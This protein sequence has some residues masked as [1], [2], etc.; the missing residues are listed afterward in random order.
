MSLSKFG[1]GRSRSL[2]HSMEIYF[3]LIYN[4]Y[5]DLTF[6]RNIHKTRLQ[7]LLFTFSYL[8]YSLFHCSFFGHSFVSFDFVLCCAH[9]ACRRTHKQGDLYQITVTLSAG[10]GQMS[11]INIEY[12]LFRAVGKVAALH[13]THYVMPFKIFSTFF[14]RDSCFCGFSSAF[15]VI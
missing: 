10:G 5:K 12:K 1:A 11:K 15:N 2:Y 3:S 8:Y 4:A 13:C 7:W 14:L 9:S 6:Q